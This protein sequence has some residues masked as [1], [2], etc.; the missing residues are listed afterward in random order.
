MQFYKKI[1]YSNASETTQLVKEA[2]QMYKVVHIANFQHDVPMDLFYSRLADFLG[3]PQSADEDILTGQLTGN[4]WIDITFDPSIPDRYRSS[5]TRQ[6]LHTD[7]SY[8]ELHNQPAIQFFYCASQAKIGGA[9]VFFDLNV[10]IECLV[11]DQEQELL[12]ALLHTDV[13]HSKG[14]ISKVRKILDKDSQDYLANWNYYCLDPQQNSPEV[15]EMCQ[16]FHLFLEE[17]IV[18]AGVVKP[19]LLK[20][21]EAVFFHDDRLL[22]GRN[23]FFASR[24][25]ERS[26]IKGKIMLEKQA[27]IA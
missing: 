5:N 13:V 24:P 10:L 12:D 21:G 23:A 27:V 8:V 11:T 25:G 4:R 6:P 2:I 22:H 16:R 9:T 7:D 26:L 17:R 20:Q 1:T 15:L 14:G 19:I 3:Q 18:K